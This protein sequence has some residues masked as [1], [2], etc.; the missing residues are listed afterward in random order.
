MSIAVRPAE[1]HEYDRVAEI[2]VAAY[3]TLPGF[4]LEGAYAEELA[5]VAGRAGS[6][7]QLVAVD[8][9]S[10]EIL[11]AVTYLDDATS[12]FAAQP[13]DRDEAA[14]RMLAVDPAAQRR[15][16]GAALVEACIQR[17]RTQRLE[18]LVLHTTEWMAAGQRLYER[19]GFRRCPERDATVADRIH[20]QS[21]V[22]DLIA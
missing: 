21:Y 20:L 18:R 2:M 14:L 9:D 17:A 7:L 16:V 3:G 12:P 11:G 13:M 19:L 4:R 15:G 22:L 1:A 8:E 6:T 5:D 10:G